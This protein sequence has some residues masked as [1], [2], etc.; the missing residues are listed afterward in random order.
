MPRNRKRQPRKRSQPQSKWLVDIVI[1]VYGKFD[2]LTRCLDSIPEAAGEIPYRIILVDNASPDRDEFYDALE[3]P[4]TLIKNTENKG[5]V[6]ASNAGAKRGKAP[7]IFM[8]N[9]DVILDPGSIEKMVGALDIPEI[10]VVGMK[11]RFPELSEH[12]HRAE[13][14]GKI[15][16]VGLATSIKGDFY[17]LFIGWDV[18]APKVNAVREVLAVTG[19]AMMTRRNLWEKIGGFNPIY[20]LGT[21]EDVEYCLNVQAMEKKVV[22][23]VQASGVHFT[24]ATAKEYNIGYPLQ[25]NNMLMKSRWVNSYPWSSWWHH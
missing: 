6:L 22:V 2:L 9:S 17:H 18:D 5:F 15:Q 7:L 21:Y 12:L 10:G 19:A 16:H 24:N 23:E 14:A 25:Q 4:V 1:C 13:D 8:L 11:L 3:T 20:G